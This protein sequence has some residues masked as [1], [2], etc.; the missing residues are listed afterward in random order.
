MCYAMNKIISEIRPRWCA[1][2]HVIQYTQKL[3]NRLETFVKKQNFTLN[4][5]IPGRVHDTQALCYTSPPGP[6]SRLTKLRD[7]SGLGG[8]PSI[9]WRTAV[10]TSTI[11]LKPGRWRGSSRQQSTISS[12]QG[13]PCEE[14]EEEEEK[15]VRH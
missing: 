9:L 5:S 4:I 2:L 14:E 6:F 8:A 15:E 10:E 7:P 1:I 3:Q 11:S 13:H 12:L